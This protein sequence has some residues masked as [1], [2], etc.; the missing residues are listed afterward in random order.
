MRPKG[1]EPDPA[2]ILTHQDTAENRQVRKD[3]HMHVVHVCR[4][5]KNPKPDSP[6]G[7]VLV[8]PRNVEIVG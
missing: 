2:M 4:V 7:E 3:P 6:A 5:H 1:A 8:V